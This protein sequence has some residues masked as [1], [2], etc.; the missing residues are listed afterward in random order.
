MD[1]VYLIKNLIDDRVNIIAVWKLFTQFRGS[2]DWHA[3]VTFDVLDAL[4]HEHLQADE[5]LYTRN[6]YSELF[7]RIFKLRSHVAHVNNLRE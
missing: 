3:R 5:A 1:V 4:I 2:Q 7:F 6:S